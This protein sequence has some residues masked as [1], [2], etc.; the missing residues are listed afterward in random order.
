MRILIFS[1]D[2]TNN[3]IKYKSEIQYLDFKSR[4]IMHRREKWHRGKLE[5]SKSLDVKEFL[6]D[7]SYNVMVDLIDQGK[8]AQGPRAHKRNRA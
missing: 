7:T 5:H 1:L 8:V 2:F 4:E 3:P 6:K